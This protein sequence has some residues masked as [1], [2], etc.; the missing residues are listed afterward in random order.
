MST[1]PAIYLAG[2][3]VFLPDAAKV[4]SG[5]A[6]IVSGAGLAPVLPAIDLDFS[7]LTQ[8]EAARAIREANRR[9]IADADGIIACVSPFRGPL[10]DPGTVWEIGYAAAHA[11]QV[12]LWREQPGGDYLSYPVATGLAEAARRMAALIEVERRDRCPA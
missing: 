11:K 4:L 1:K 5:M 10:P 9:R 3:A 12:I 2:P 7:N 8:G 6:K